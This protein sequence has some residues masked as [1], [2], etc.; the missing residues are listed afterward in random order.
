MIIRSKPDINYSILFKNNKEYNNANFQFFPYGRDA[1]IAGLK[2]LNLKS[3]DELLLPSYICNSVSD[4]LISEGFKVFFIDINK[5]MNLSCE[6]IKTFLVGKNIK[7]IVIVHYFG[8]L[9]NIDELEELCADLK[10]VL[11]ED[12]SHSFFP[13][14]Y[15]DRNSLS[16]D[17]QIFSLRKNLPVPDG[18]GL[19][20]KKN[21]H[22]SSI[23]RSS[24]C[25]SH[26]NEVRFLFIRT[27]ERIFT[28]LGFNS[29]SNSF[30]KLKKLKSEKYYRASTSCEPSYSITAH[31]ANKEYM[32]VIKK[33]ISENYSYLLKEITK[34]DLELLIYHKRETDSPQAL[35]VLDE[36]E[37]LLDYLRKK[38]VGAW[39]WPG[40]ELPQEIISAQEKFPNTIFFN[41]KIVLLPIH[42]SLGKNQLDYIIKVLVNWKER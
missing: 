38:G 26:I 33:R 8:L 12:F 10:I 39:C 40:D 30:L 15:A 19:S 5:E 36:S 2:K 13:L 1:L 11:V 14:Y 7:A 29:Y 17:L 28:F 22:K 24:C 41:K 3:N 27:I 25:L 20:I 4:A 18:G 32:Y 16:S 23:K 42:F 34:L 6:S 9:R 37:T 35:V 21:F 31:L